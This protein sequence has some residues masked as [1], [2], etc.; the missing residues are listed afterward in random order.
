MG[1]SPRIGKLLE[2][3]DALAGTAAYAHAGLLDKENPGLSPALPAF[4]AT[5]AVDRIDILNPLDIEKDIEM[6]GC[7]TWAGSSSMDVR[8]EVVHDDGDGGKIPLML[9]DFVMV[10]R[11][12]DGTRAHRVPPLIPS[13]PLE[14]HWNESAALKRL[15]RKARKTSGRTLVVEPPT[16]EEQSHL[17]DLWVARTAARDN[18]VRK[19]WKDMADTSLQS[20]ILT[21]PQ[22]KNIHGKIFGGFLMRNAF[23]LAYTDTLLHTRGSKKEITFR[24]VSDISFKSPVEIGSVLQLQSQIVYAEDS[25]VHTRVEAVVVD[26]VSATRNTTNVFHF[27]FDLGDDLSSPKIMPTT[28][29]ESMFYISGRRRSIDSSWAEAIRDFEPTDFSR[30]FPNA[31]PIPLEYAAFVPSS[32]DHPRE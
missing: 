32:S 30:L 18:P 12:A 15:N 24:T 13:S 1:D 22:S 8:L 16:S 11:S 2:I 7:V 31:S 14:L 26:P 19:A 3:L 9:A 28:Y 27:M 20:T 25:C 10:G 6:N 17:A 21:M 4:F 23:E 29:E 5:A